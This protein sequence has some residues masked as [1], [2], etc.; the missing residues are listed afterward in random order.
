M[1]D[2]V[3]LEGLDSQNYIYISLDRLRI[4]VIVI[5]YDSVGFASL[6][7]SSGD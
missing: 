2:G 5:A 4:Y 1:F 7:R 6:E 3:R